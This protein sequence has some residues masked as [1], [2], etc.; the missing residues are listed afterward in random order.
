M[1]LV[2]Y[3]QT[4]INNLR[5]Y[6]GKMT[7]SDANEQIESFEELADLDASLAAETILANLFQSGTYNSSFQLNKALPYDYQEELLTDLNPII[8][9]ILSDSE[10]KDDEINRFMHNFLLS[11]AE[12]IPETWKVIG[13]EKLAFMPY[14][15]NQDGSISVISKG[16]RSGVKAVPIGNYQGIDYTT[17]IPLTD[18]FKVGTEENIERQSITKEVS[19][20]EEITNFA[21]T[22]SK[23]QM[24]RV[25]EKFGTNDLV[26]IFEEHPFATNV[27]D[28]VDEINCL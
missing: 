20:S 13:N 2:N 5:L 12:H 1:P 7:T 17:E 10:I 14:G 24:A 19:E 25:V 22:L 16:K 28:F 3:R 27:K 15:K 21:K 11:H 26:K 6:K 8:K 4:G 18:N 23:E 9:E